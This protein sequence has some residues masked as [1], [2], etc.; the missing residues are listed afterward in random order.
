MKNRKSIFKFILIFVTSF[1]LIEAIEEIIKLYFG[2]ELNEMKWGWFGLIVLYGIKY[3]IFCCVLPAI[4]I[5][6][7]CR[8]KKCKHEHCEHD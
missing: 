6:Y 3:H 4:W 8:H 5:G 1:I 7:K 2:V